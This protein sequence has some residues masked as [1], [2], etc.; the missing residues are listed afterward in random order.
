MNHYIWLDRPARIWEEA[1]PIG[2]GTLGAMVFGDTQKERIGLNIDTLWSGTGKKKIRGSTKQVLENIRRHIKSGNPEAAEVLMQEAFLNEWN[3]SYLPLGDL[4]IVFDRLPNVSVY[5]RELNFQKGIAKT[6]FTSGEQKV[7]MEAF[8]SA[9]ENV[10]VVSVECKIRTNITLYLDSQIQNTKEVKR[11]TMF[12]YGNAPS[13]VQPNYYEC[14]EPITYSAKKPGMGFS[15]G[16]RVLSTDGTV[17]ESEGRLSVEG[18]TSATL[19]VAANTAYDAENGKINKTVKTVRDECISRLEEL[20]GINIEHVKLEHVKDFASFYNRTEISL[21]EEQDNLPTNLR[22]ENFAKNNEDLGMPELIFNLGKYLLISCSR[23]NSMAANLQGIWNDKLR[24]P[25]SSNY[26]TNINTQMNYWLAEKCNLPEMHLPLMELLRHCVESGRETA[27]EQFGCRGWVANHNIDC[28]YQ[29]SPVGKLSVKPSSKYGYFPMASGWLCLHIW[30]HYLYTLDHGFLEK[31][32]SIMKEASLFYRD[33]L[34]KAGENYEIIPSTSPENL[35]F[36]SRKKECALSI[37]TTMD[38]SIVRM[39]FD[40]V[41]QAGN[42]LECDRDYL[43]ELAEVM[44]HL[45]G[46]RIGKNGSLQEWS[47]DYKEVYPKHRHISHLIGLYPGHEFEQKEDLLKAC[48][49][50]LINRTAEGTAWCKIWK[51]CCWSRLKNGEKAFEHLCGFLAPMKSTDIGYLESGCQDN[52]LCTPPF[53]IDG[54][55]GAVAA[56]L[57][58]LIQDKRG[59]VSFLPALPKSW[60]RGALKGIKIIGNHVVDFNWTDGKVV[61]ITIKGGSEE[62]LLCVFNKDMKEIDVKKNRIINICT[63]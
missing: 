8:A 46:Y 15:C 2:N 17:K 49:K 40:A 23:E 53:Q 20:K 13:N 24:A 29:T 25:W 27:K 63:E 4:F 48:E 56:I 16:V 37:S 41:I 44:E 55:L 28:W 22:L 19:I 21:C 7:H 26:T 31:Y 39:L 10:I 34:Q 42:V 6:D 59:E 18:M 58:M 57:E 5:R 3:E 36:N 33:Y 62:K 43:D 12:F 35:Y 50:T 51:S 1:F 38:I 47:E 61:N 52:L 9:Q 45:P 30:E 14:D 60:Q 32:Y 11:S 54:N